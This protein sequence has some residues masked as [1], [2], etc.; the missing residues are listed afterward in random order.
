MSKVLK[1]TLLALTAAA[2]ISSAAQ[3]ANLLQ[4]V[5]ISA[6]AEPSNKLPTLE[7][8]LKDGKYVLGK[9]GP[10]STLKFVV[11]AKKMNDGRI[12]SYRVES[13]DSKKQIAK[14]SGFY[15]KKLSTSFKHVVPGGELNAL[16]T[17][18]RKL[19]EINGDRDK[20][21]TQT[22][23]PGLRYKLVVRA[24]AL[25]RKGEDYEN[26]QA[27]VPVKV[28]CHPEAFKVK[29]ADLTVKFDGSPFQCPVKATLTAK[30]KTNKPGTFKFNLY[31]GDGAFQTVTR[32]AGESGIV[33]FKK[34]YTFKK[35]AKRKYLIAVMGHPIS[36][37]WVPMN[38]N[39]NPKV[40]GFKAPT[41]PHSTNY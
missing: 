28:I 30:F 15:E 11:K 36:T 39:C 14:M 38:V 26:R 24:V 27:R 20:V 23:K 16:V 7:F 40:D 18:G 2:A 32:T 8:V 25:A 41:K 9:G 17:T 33:T 13:E 1:T 31:R 5:S 12:V 35:A 29:D 6:V 37:Q 22:I 19:C 21:I 4:G 3:A 10:K 34:H